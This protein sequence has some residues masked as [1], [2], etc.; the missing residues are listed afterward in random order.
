MGTLEGFPN[1]PALWLCRA[2]P[3][4]AYAIES[5][6]LGG[7]PNPPALWLCRAKPGSAYA[8]LPAQHGSGWDGVAGEQGLGRHALAAG[9]LDF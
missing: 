4:S 6:T 1:P 9:Q 7:F 8:P 3:G 5:G 2:K